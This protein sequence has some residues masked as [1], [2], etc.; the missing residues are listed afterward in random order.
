[1]A[2]QSGFSSPIRFLFRF[3]LTTGVVW[4][5]STYVDQ[6]FT[7]TGGLRAYLIV[8]LLLTIMNMIVRPMLKVLLAPFHFLFGFIAT[9]A[10]NLFFLWLIVTIAS[11]FD[12]SIVFLNING[13][14][15]GWIVVAVIVGVADWCIKTLLRA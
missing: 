1:M 7:L 9:I 3:V 6:Y 13:G 8:G 4:F 15:V 11:T 14:I 10:T 2:E 12:P 5:L